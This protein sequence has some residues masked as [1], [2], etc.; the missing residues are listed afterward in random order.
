MRRTLI[1]LT[2]A[3]VTFLLGITS[4]GIW[5][6]HHDLKNPKTNSLISH[7]IEEDNI[8][9][10]VF[11]YQM[12]KDSQLKVYFLS[13]NDN[14]PDGQFMRRFE[15]QLPLVKKKSQSSHN[16]YGSILDKE[17][18]E[19]AA[20]LSVGQI[21]WINDSEVKVSGSIFTGEVAGY[22]YQVIR[23]GNR[24]IVKSSECVLES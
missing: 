15:G 18:G 22:I 8:A 20:I 17:T 23:E 21:E 3:F 16:R 19:Y 14:D 13:R 1:G 9:E 11:R 4:V 7:S 24:W 6:A 10:T 12:P 5:S 2:A